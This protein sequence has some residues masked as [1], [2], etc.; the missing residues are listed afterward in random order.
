MPSALFILN[1]DLLKGKELRVLG[2]IV[3]GYLDFAEGLIVGSGKNKHR[4]YSLK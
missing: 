2:Q 4:T 3:S 1:L